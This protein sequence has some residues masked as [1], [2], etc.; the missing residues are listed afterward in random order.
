MIKITLNT[1]AAKNEK[2]AI[3]SKILLYLILSHMYYLCCCIGIVL[4]M[5]IERQNGTLNKPESLQRDW[6]NHM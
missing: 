1:V 4:N 6:F 5:P 2:I 3:L